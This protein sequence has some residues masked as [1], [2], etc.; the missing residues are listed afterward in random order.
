MKRA[1]STVTWT[2]GRRQFLALSA[3]GLAG[4]LAACSSGT[5]PSPV[6]STAPQ[7]STAPVPSTAAQASA[8]P[9]ASAAATA[10]RPSAVAGG[11]TPQSS[12][13]PT[14]PKSYKE[15]PALAEQVKAGKLPAAAD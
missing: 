5:L 11:A 9:Q 2:I 12:A 1:E 7:A 6:A 3:S 10:A 4:L 8:A 14:T 15:A 13:P